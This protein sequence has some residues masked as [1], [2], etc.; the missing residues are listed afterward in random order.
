MHKLLNQEIQSLKEDLDKREQEIFKLKSLLNNSTASSAAN[1]L[2]LSNGL[3]NLNLNNLN[4]STAS[5]MNSAV[6]LSN[7][8]IGSSLSH[9]DDTLEAAYDT[10][11][12]LESWLSI[13]NKRNIKKHGWKKLY[14]VLKKGK[15]FFYN[16]LRD[17]DSQEPYMTIDLE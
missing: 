5:P 12:R 6:N 14:V 4:I 2:S 16:S 15:I 11:D 17:K 8:S 7:I 10:Q 3:A 1:L 13:P 9:F